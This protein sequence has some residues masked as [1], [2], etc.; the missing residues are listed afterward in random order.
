[1]TRIGD[2]GTP[3]ILNKDEKLAYYV[4]LC[5]FTNIDEEVLI[6]I[7]LCYTIELL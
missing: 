1:M 6:N 4:T 3:A 7:I 2:I 5:L